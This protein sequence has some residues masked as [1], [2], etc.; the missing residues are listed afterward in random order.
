MVHLMGRSQEEYT[1]TG[2]ADEFTAYL[3][4][5]EY[6]SP[7]SAASVSNPGASF[8]VLRGRLV[9]LPEVRT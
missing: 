5:I 3:K 9:L 2:I 8:V 4:S 1:T 7:S 6:K